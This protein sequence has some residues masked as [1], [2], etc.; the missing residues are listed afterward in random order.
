MIKER[1]ASKAMVID[2]VLLQS[3]CYDCPSG[4]STSLH[5]EFLTYSSVCADYQEFTQ[6]TEDVD[7]ALTPTFKRYRDQVLQICLQHQLGYVILCRL[8]PMSLFNM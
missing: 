4:K 2:E 1:L 6:M 3:L 7:D 8:S 5:H